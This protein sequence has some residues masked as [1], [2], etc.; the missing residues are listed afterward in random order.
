MVAYMPTAY[1][2]ALIEMKSSIY[3]RV[4]EPPRWEFCT[5][6][7]DNSLGFATGA[8]YV[9]EYLNEDDRQSV[10][11]FALDFACAAEPNVFHVVSYHE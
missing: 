5:K 8:L 4:A 6:H 9:D 11:D 10:F 3:G 2:L 7:A 1:V